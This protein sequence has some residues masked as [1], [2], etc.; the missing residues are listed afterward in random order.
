MQDMLLEKSRDVLLDCCL[1]NGAIIAANTDRPDYPHLVQSYRYVWPRDAAYICYALGILGIKE[2][3]AGFFRWLGRAEGLRENGLLFQNYYTN[4]RKRWLAFQPDQNG[5]VLWALHNFIKKY[6]EYAGEFTPLAKLLADGLCRA[7]N[8]EHFN[9]VAQDLWEIFYAYP[10][11]NTT[12]TYSLAACA[13]GLKCAYEIVHDKRYIDIRNQMTE[14]IDRSCIGGIFARRCGISNDMRPDIS[15]LGLVWPFSVLSADDDRVRKTVMNI[16]KNLE[17][18]GLFFR[19]Q[20][21]DYD[22]FRYE[23]NDARRGAGTWPIGSFWMSIFYSMMGDRK[24]AAGYFSNVTRMLDKNRNIPE[25]VFDNEIQVSVKPLA[26]SHAMH[27]I[28]ASFLHNGDSGSG[29][30]H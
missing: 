16:H 28:A 15:L 10:E 26:W 1:E 4:G 22:C 8:G 21:D 30:Q 29:N 12:L 11:M 24:K 25:Q 2:Q 3:Q 5:S 14:K 6:P 20:Y 17:K 9:L 27:V 18:N 7:W 23:G 13:H 19:F